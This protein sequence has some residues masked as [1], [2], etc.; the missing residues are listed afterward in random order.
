M[1]F[2]EE[3]IKAEARVRRMLRGV[4]AEILNPCGMVWKYCR[5][6]VHSSTSILRESDP[7]H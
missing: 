4:K 6:G 5:E 2:Q 1:K 7:Y 3:W